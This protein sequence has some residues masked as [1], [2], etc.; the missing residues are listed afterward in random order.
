MPNYSFK[1]DSEVYVVF[2]G[3]QYSIDVSDIVYGQS[4]QESS[5]KQKTLQ[6][7][8]YFDGVNTYILE[9]ASFTI[10][11]YAIREKDFEVLFER[12]LDTL[13]FD[14]YIKTEQD[15]FKL[16]YAIVSQVSFKVQKNNPLGLEV[17]GEASLLTRVGSGS[18]TV[19]GTVIDRSGTKT[20][21]LIKHVKATIDGTTEYTSLTSFVAELKNEI[22]WTS[23]ITVP[24]NCGIPETAVYPTAFTIGK[25]IL[26]GSFALH[27]IENFPYSSSA[28]LSLEAGEYFGGTLYGFLFNI[29]KVLYTT[30]INTGAVFTQRYLWTMTH[31]PDSLFQVISYITSTEAAANAI[32]D[33]LGDPILD[34]LGDPIL[35]S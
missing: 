16:E 10:T 28:L 12:G 33:H 31:N 24:E 9:P 20:F 2:G 25:R 29:P 4:Y 7:Q 8:N 6:D 17:S 21:N 11:F 13:T 32:L 30:T 23:Y 19:P 34:H 18:Y 15:T 14:L 3:N 26:E 27:E 5:Y 1:R 22:N 35:E